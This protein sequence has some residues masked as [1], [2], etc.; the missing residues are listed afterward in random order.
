M[1]PII[2]KKEVTKYI[3]KTFDI[4]MS[5]KLGQNFLIDETVVNNIVKA[6]EIEEGETVLEIGPG[7]GT[8]TQ[9]LAEAKANVI[10]VEI[11]NKLPAVLAK[12]LEGYDNVR[13]VHDDILKVNIRELVEDKPFKVVANLPYYITTP[14]IMG[15]LEQKLP[16]T[17][18]VTMIQKRLQ[19]E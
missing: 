10:A 4:H 12:T 1:K 5:K 16:V 6:A 3:L 11:D 15:I 14:I 13:I 19:T 17:R 8:L 2:A 7:I 18:L 9:A